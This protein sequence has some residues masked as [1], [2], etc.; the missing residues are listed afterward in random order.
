VFL[1]VLPGVLC[2]ERVGSLERE[3][4]HTPEERGPRR[5]RAKQTFLSK[6]RRDWSHSESRQKVEKKAFCKESFERRVCRDT[7]VPVSL[8]WGFQ[9]ALVSGAK[10][11]LLILSWA[12][13]RDGSREGSGDGRVAVTGTEASGRRR[14]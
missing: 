12:M 11:R 4:Q 9:L 6:G 2:E 13:P 5:C 8:I 14:D 7:C 10:R 3:A 1:Y